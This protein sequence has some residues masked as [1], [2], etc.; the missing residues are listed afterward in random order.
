M[1]PFQNAAYLVCP[2]CVFKAGQVFYEQLV[3][4]SHE[5]VCLFGTKDGAAGYNQVVRREL[6]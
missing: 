2:C 3:Q 6:L 5:A 4:P 1:P